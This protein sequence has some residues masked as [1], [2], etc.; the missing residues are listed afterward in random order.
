MEILL[1][2]F[3]LLFNVGI[4]IVLLVAAVIFLREHF[5]KKN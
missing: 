1:M 2:A 5:S 3:S 4:P